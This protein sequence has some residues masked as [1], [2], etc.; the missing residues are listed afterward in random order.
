V[1]TTADDDD[2]DLR[3]YDERPAAPPAA[4]QGR[5]RGLFTG[6]RDDPRWARPG[7]LALLAATGGPSGS[8]AGRA[9]WVACSTARPPAALS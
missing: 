5:L 9:A 4:T 3:Q 7:L 6:N 8:A 2:T 1:T